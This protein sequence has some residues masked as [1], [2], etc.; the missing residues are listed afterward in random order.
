VREQVEW[1]RARGLAVRF[2]CGGGWYMDERVAEVLAAAG[3][4]DCTATAFRPR[5]LDRAAVRLA[6]REPCV[7]EL[8]SGSRLLELP[9][10]HTIGMLARG[11]LAPFRGSVVHAYFHDTDLL[12]GRRAALLS[13]GLRFLGMKRT[14]TDLDELS[15]AAESAPRRPFRDL[16]AA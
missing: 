13:V 10:T 1:L 11:L 9:T 2:F 4:S 7:V 5:Y 12:D 15:S 8:A 6:A 16:A 3:L 14:R